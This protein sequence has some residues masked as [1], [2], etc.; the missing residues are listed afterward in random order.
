VIQIGDRAFREVWL[1]D[2]EFS[3]A[4]GERPNVVCL[5]AWEIASSQKLRIWQDELQVMDC[6]PYA[7]DEQALFVA[8][9]ASAEMSCH[10]ALGWSL[11]LNVLDLFIEFR[12]ATNG[13][14]LP[15][16]AGL[17]G[18]LT[19]YGLGGIETTEKESMRELAQRGGPWSKS[20]KQALLDYCE[21]DV[22]ALARL[23]PKM[24]SSLDVSRA[25]LRGRYMKAA[26]H[27][28]DNGIP[29]DTQSLDRLRNQWEV[30]QY[31]LIAEID[32][33]YG[34]YEGH[35]FKAV[36][37]AEY[38]AAND[39]PWPQLPKG[40][41][42]LK[43]DTFR[44][45]ARSHPSIAPLRELRVA[46]SQ[47]RLSELAVGKDGRNRC[48][49][50]AFRARTGRNQPSNSKFIFGPAV[51]LRG[52]I[53]PKQGHGIAYIDWSQQEFGVA[54]ALSN[55]PLMQEA[56]LSGDPYL[57]FAK[58]A[59]AVPEDAT[60]QSH[61]AERNQFKACVL[62]VQYGMGAQ[63]LAQRIGQPV[64]RAKELLQ[65]HRETYRVFWAWSDAAVDHAMLHGKLWTV[66]GW[67]VRTGTNPNPRFLRN[68]LMQ[69]MARR[70]FAW[71]AASWWRPES[72]SVPRCMTRY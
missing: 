56:Y 38:L 2:F 8:Y 64:I 30:I 26:A 35:S 19:W 15:C 63:S 3:A 61:K 12:N 32:D 17:L 43:D 46:L 66:F 42:D 39:I 44:E 14:T 47:M 52:L 51:W 40:G 70:C 5:V 58:Q 23:L 24:A 50:S 37:F 6:P 21:A 36:R 65:L 69:E 45:M 33:D 16:G 27:I 57:A 20:E 60:K 9:Y 7:V 11:P 22:A 34:V 41:L 28:E 48:L 62:A 72:L 55:D 54:A 29:I 25:L 31:R 4:P 59:G 67:T 71:P 18:A 49:L 10:L 68:F 1:V 13:L 53:Q